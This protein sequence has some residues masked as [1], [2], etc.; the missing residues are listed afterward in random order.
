M[1]QLYGSIMRT[2]IRMNEE[3]ARRAKAYA[4][5]NRQSFTEVVETAVADFLARFPK[6]K[7]KKRIVLPVVGD[8]TH[9][10]DPEEL[11]RAIEQADLE[12]DLKKIWGVRR[13]GH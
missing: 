3:L 2:T 13:A 8:P 10:V 12:Y 1:S 9:K 6:G 7:P 11:K 4:A 5:R